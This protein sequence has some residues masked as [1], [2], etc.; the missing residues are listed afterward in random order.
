[1]QAVE[2]SS[3]V[4]DVCSKVVSSNYF[5]THRNQHKYC[6]YCER[7]HSLKDPLNCPLVAEVIERNWRADT[8]DRIKSTPPVKDEETLPLPNETLYKPNDNEMRYY[9][10][11]LYY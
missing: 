7:Y 4:C 3:V 2:R 6:S 1:M 11:D 5:V 8:L 9:F 10:P